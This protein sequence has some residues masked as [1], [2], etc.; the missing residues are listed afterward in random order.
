LRIFIDSHNPHSQGARRLAEYL[1]ARRIRQ[2]GSRYR[3]R[4]SDVVI[5]WGR[6]ELGSYARDP[7]RWDGIP[8]IINDQHAVAKA[9][10]KLFT[11]QTL[12]NSNESIR[13]DIGTGSPISFPEYTT[14][15]V[16][17]QRWQSEGSLIVSRSLLRASEGRGMEIGEFALE[18]IEGVPVRLWVKY[19][20]KSREYRVHVFKG[21]VIDIQQKKRVRSAVTHGVDVDEQIRSHANGWIFA[22]E[23]I[24]DNPEIPV[25][26]EQAILAVKALGLDFGAV[27]II[28]SIKKNRCWVL[29]VNCAPGLEGTTVASYGEAIRRYI[30]VERV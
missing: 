23:G 9:S 11:F 10:D 20:R 26:K 15:W 2:V 14:D 3:P 29:E 21:E 6:S 28:Y 24:L 1:N 16:T 18:T 19:K 17:A 27:D 22:R 7:L 5:N 25:I 12:H 4:R 13:Y 8:T 30:D